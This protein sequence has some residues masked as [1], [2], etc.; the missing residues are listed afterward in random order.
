M[1]GIQHADIDHAGLTGVGDLSG[2]TGDAT[3]AHDA[4]AISFTPAGTIAATEVQAAIEELDTTVAAIPAGHVTFTIGPYMINDL[5]GTATTQML[6]PFFN[7]SALTSL[8]A[9]GVEYR[10]PDASHVIGAILVTDNART[11]GSAELRVRVGG[12]ATVFAAGAVVLDGTNT[13]RVAAFV[14]HASGIAA[15]AG[16]S[17]GVAIVTSGWTPTSANLNVLLVISLD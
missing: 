11:A 10:I 2:H 4:S 14:D 3:D 15:T 17:I 5:P 16:S 6:L 13:T 1:A 12:V 9:N 7:T 8:G